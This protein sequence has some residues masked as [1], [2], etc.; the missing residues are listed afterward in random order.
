MNTALDINYADGVL[1]IEI[2]EADVPSFRL[3][4]SRRIGLL[5][6]DLRLPPATSGT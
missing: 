3:V 5:V 6:I 2:T 1:C 4:D